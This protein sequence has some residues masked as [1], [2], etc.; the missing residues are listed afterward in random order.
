M[1]RIEPNLEEKIKIR[2]AIVPIFED[3]LKNIKI[4]DNRQNI[5]TIPVEEI[6]KAFDE[7]VKKLDVKLPKTQ[8][9]KGAV[10]ITNQKEIQK[11]EVINNPEI[12]IESKEI[13]FPE[14]QKI[15]GEVKAINLPVG[16]DKEASRNAN[17][18]NYLIV[19]LTDG[20][21]FIDNFGATTSAPMG[22]NTENIFLREEYS[23]IT[24]SGIQVVNQIKKWTDTMILTEDYQYDGNANPIKKFRSI[25]P[26]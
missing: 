7:A 19:R 21:R 22:R 2:K 6:K 9:I 24:I 15:I 4:E 20:Q 3:M 18:T 1:D 11:V 26:L 16:N 14:L 17:P 13:N 25:E 10:E 12:N 5:I 23:Y 8:T